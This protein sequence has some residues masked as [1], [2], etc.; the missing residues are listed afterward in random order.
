MTF[1]KFKSD[2]Y[3]FGRRHKSATVKIYRDVTSKGNKVIIGYCSVCNRK[4]SIYCF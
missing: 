2:S 1:R 3:C 4:K